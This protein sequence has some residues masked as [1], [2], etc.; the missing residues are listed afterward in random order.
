MSAHVISGKA[1]A[2]DLRARVADR[3]MSLRSGS[4]RPGLATLIVG[5]RY[6]ARAYER[7]LR[8]LA[9][10]LDCHYVCESLSGE[11]GQDE[12]LAAIGKLGGDP[13][14]SGILV[15][16]P[17]PE[18]ISEVSLYQ[19]IAP[20]KDIEAMHPVNAGLFALG[21]P[22][23]VPSTPA[24]AFHM[25]DCYLR[26]TGRD[27]SDV[28]PAANLVVVGRSNNVG[29]PAAL[30]ALARDATLVSCDIHTSRAGLLR[31]HT[32]AADILIVAVGVPG[33]ITA[34]DVKPGAIVIDIGINAVP[35]ERTGKTRLVGDVDIA[36]VGAIAE[37]VSPV[38]GGVGPIT[39]TWLLRNTVLAAELS[40]LGRDGVIT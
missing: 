1:I 29:R 12:V 31:G 24:S 22:R 14:I 23:Y 7:R 40:A 16:R 19:A 34:D 13:R 39:D 35:D 17:L 9:G 10:E 36:S 5:E 32:S 26:S 2:A 4:V 37:A 27:P 28:Y 15:L 33:L 11:V 30:L 8:R 6:E 38:P 21:R 18:H 3:V 20:L 25:I